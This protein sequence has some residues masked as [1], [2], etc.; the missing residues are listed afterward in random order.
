MIDKSQSTQGELPT[1]TSAADFHCADPN[2]T[3]HIKWNL[4]IFDLH[5][6]LR[7]QNEQEELNLAPNENVSQPI[8]QRKNR[9]KKNF[10][11]INNNHGYNL[12]P[13]SA[14]RIP[15]MLN[16]ATA[17]LQRRLDSGTLR[18][19]HIAHLKKYTTLKEKH[20]TI[21]I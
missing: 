20:F 19:L 13:A 17:T 18:F 2:N 12:R 15:Q 6:K 21:F 9:K 5:N 8:K 7:K 4:T 3:E 11:L 14:I 10:T 1:G 16:T